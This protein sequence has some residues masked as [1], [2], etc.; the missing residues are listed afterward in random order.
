MTDITATIGIEQLKKIDKILDIKNN[1]AEK[2]NKN[3]LTKN[4][5]KYQ[6]YPIIPISLH[7]ICIQLQFLKK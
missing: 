6:K 7:G 4:Q 3:L 1:I 5:L 2:Y